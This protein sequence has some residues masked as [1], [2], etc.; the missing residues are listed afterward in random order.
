[1]ITYRLVDNLAWFSI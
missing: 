1:M